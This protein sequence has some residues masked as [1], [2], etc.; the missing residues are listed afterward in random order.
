MSDNQKNQMLADL[1]RRIQADEVY[2]GEHMGRVFVPGQGN[3]EDGAM[4]FVGEAPGRE[5]EMERRPFV[6]QAGKNLN[7]LLAEVGL[8]R[9]KLFI[10]NLVKYRPLSKTGGNRSPSAFERR[11]A[12]PYLLREL[13]IL[14]PSMVVCLGLSSAKSVL[15]R[16][17][18]KMSESNGTLFEHHGLRILVT[19][20]PSPFNTSNP[21][22]RAA[23]LQALLSLKNS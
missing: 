3:L 18:L 12:L 10:T 8:D 13:S 19:Y 5:E 9:D 20:H 16:Q 14:E 17:D 11:R 2:R 7:A 1:Y 23:I 15:G 4:V 6:G 22:K 21:R